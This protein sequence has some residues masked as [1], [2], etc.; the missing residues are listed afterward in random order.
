M[1]ELKSQTSGSQKLYSQL[2]IKK[3]LAFLESLPP[4][5]VLQT[6]ELLGA[7]KHV[8]MDIGLHWRDI[9]CI[10]R[11]ARSEGY[12][13]FTKTLPVL[14]KAFDRALSSGNF[15]L[16]TNFKKA[17]GKSALPA[18]LGSL[19]RQVFADDGS[20]LSSASAISV[21]QIRQVCF[22]AYK[23]NLPYTP[24]QEE[25]VL[26]RFVETEQELQSFH[27][28]ENDP[29]LKFGNLLVKSVFDGFDPD[30]LA[31]KHG[32]GITSN[33]PVTEK[34]EHKL[35]ALPSVSHF[36]KHFFFNAEDG[37][38]RLDRYP[39]YRTD[40]Y[41]RVGTGAKV[42]LVPKDSRGPR[43]ISCEP[44]ENQFIQQGILEFMVRRLE[45]HPITGGQVNF[46]DQ[47][48]NR[49]LARSG[50][51]SKKWATLDLKDAS[52]RVHMDVF[53]AL[54]KDTRILDSLLAS[55]SVFTTL[56]DGR[57]VGL[58]KFAPMGSACCFPVMATCIY[59]ML[60][61]AFIGYG[62][63]PDL[64]SRSIYVYG[65][66][67]VVPSSMAQFAMEVLERYCLRVNKDK[68]F[69]SS[70]FLESCGLDAFDGNDVSPI[71]L[72]TLPC[73]TTSLTVSPN[74]LEVVSL[75]ETANHL[76]RLGYSKTSGYLYSCVEQL[77]GSLPYGY[78]HSPYLN[79]NILP[80][81]GTAVEMNAQ[82]GKRL[83]SRVKHRFGEL[84]Q[85]W[86]LYRVQAKRTI[87]G[88]TPFGHLMRTFPQLGSDSVV[89]GFGEF[90]LPRDCVLKIVDVDHVQ[91]SPYPGGT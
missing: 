75:V 18:F 88:E 26:N 77:L 14:G 33:V 31:F 42:I 87:K 21:Q 19:F 72:R 41:F 49:E 16:P 40:D 17:S 84:R 47:T 30:A 32:P 27:V 35:S 67:I 2:T 55:R 86:R 15:K 71:R 50:S 34:F 57:R 13:F 56:P 51:M 5:A 66:D 89:D 39:V 90:R 12:S 70:R 1:R 54:F 45:S 48:I 74:K 62:M 76:S 6:E 8:L 38:T 28:S 68:S 58:K 23:T 11:R 63:L 85:V 78:P 10:T 60:Y 9:Q 20:L 59:A 44:A 52:D 24:S 7:Y 37:V 73:K 46:T 61:A 25:S 82:L 4:K 79:R 64:A 3:A 80:V 43:L 65:D 81:Q 22:F 29:I 91:M 53:V 83:V 69:V 36:S